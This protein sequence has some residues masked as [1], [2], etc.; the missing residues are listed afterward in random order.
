VITSLLLAT[1]LAAAP[2]PRLGAEVT[3]NRETQGPVVSV[4]GTV[5]VAAE[6]HGDVVALGGDV[7]LGAGGRVDGDVVAIGGS[8]TGEGGASKRIVSFPA[9]DSLPSGRLARIDSARAAW[10]VRL[11][12]VGGWMVVATALLLV[13]PRQ[14]RRGGE[15]LRIMPL[16][17][18]AVGAL[19]LAV[20]LVLVLLALGLSG[21]RL[22]VVLL[23]S[24]VAVLLA[25]KLL[26]LLAVAWLAGVGLREALPQGWRGEI[27][28]TGLGM[29]TLAAVG[30]LPLV[31][32]VVWLAA[33][34]AGIGAMV[35]TVVAPRL[36]TL[37][38]TARRPASA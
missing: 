1:T 28:R 33:N 25:G 37:T 8:V 12:R 4:L 15:Q 36:V 19:S 29:L 31:G 9:L 14:A 17:T 27:P 26:G 18:L 32:P 5:N 21:S 6:V 35:A 16:R 20:W 11:T 30:L 23:L 3:I 10:G 24:G 22:G 34:V 7:V 2:P 38:L 13:W